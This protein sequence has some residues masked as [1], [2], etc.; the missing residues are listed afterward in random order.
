MKNNN[1]IYE[2][3]Y[4]SKPLKL[5]FSDGTRG[6]S[7]SVPNGKHSRS[8]GIKCGTFGFAVYEEKGVTNAEH[9]YHFEVKFAGA[10]YVR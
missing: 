8:A 6:H 4:Y 2:P 7:K 9:I 10:Q 3:H 1:R 5:L